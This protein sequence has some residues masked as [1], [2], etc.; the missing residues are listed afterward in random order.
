VSRAARVGNDVVD[1]GDPM[2]ASAHTRERLVARVLHEDERALL[3]ASQTPNELFWS[4][5]AAKEAAFKVVCKIGPRPVFAH[6]R[7]VVASDLRS[8]RH[9]DVVLELQVVT[10]AATYVHAIASTATR[11]PLH[12][13][14]PIALD[15]NPTAAGRRHLCE[16]VARA[17]DCE[18]SELDVVRVPL[19]ESWDGEGPP[20]LIRAGATLDADVSLS[21]DGRFV[22]FAAYVT[23]TAGDARAM[24]GAVPDRERSAG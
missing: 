22:A 16:W 19:A 5:F 13:V 17:L 2:N 11:A 24:A 12:A 15:A 20:Q 10:V 4:L 14:E 18:A 8:V 1:L 7:F 23:A 9:A 3:R 21:H 6:R